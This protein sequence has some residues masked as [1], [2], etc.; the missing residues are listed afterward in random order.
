[1][2]QSRLNGRESAK[3]A[4][5]TVSSGHL[6]VHDTTEGRVRVHLSVDDRSEA[7]DGHP[8]ETPVG[9]R[10]AGRD[11]H[12]DLDVLVRRGVLGPAVPQVEVPVSGVVAGGAVVVV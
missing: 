2:D 7:A 10:W 4:M 1:M 6:P 5:R 9:A 3:R 8:A 12:V 11:T